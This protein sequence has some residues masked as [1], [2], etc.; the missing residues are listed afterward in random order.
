M[1]ARRRRRRRADVRRSITIRRCRRRSGSRVRRS[2]TRGRCSSRS[3]R[4]SAKRRFRSACTRR[5]RR[6]ALPLAG[7]DVGQ[8]AY[9]VATLQLQPQTE[10]V[11]TVFKDGWHPA[12]VAEHNATRRVAVDEEGRDAGVQEPEEGLG[13]LSRR[14]QPGQRVQ[15]AAAG[16]GRR[17]AAR[18]VD[19]FTLQP[20]Q[21][22]LR[23]IPL[24]GG[25]AWQRRR[26]GA[27]HFGR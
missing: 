21:P 5:R 1:V 10:N 15:R 18:C 23:K 24:Q 6:S 26:G 4:T 7:D 13:V 22:S 8:R 25:P 11:F 14:R 12:E 9:Q 19:E 16:Q 20:K 3:I 27:R 2:S 17:W